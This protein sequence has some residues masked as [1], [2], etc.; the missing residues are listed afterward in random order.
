MCVAL[1][2]KERTKEAW[3]KLFESV[4]KRFE[5]KSVVHPE[6][7]VSTVIEFVLKDKA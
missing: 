5:L 2:S 3:E 6:K 7:P 4:D 1:S